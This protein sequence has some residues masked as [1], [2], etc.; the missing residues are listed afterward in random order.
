MR[1]FSILLSF[2]VCLPVLA[3]PLEFIVKE[4]G[5]GVPIEEATVV[6]EDGEI[7]GMTDK[8]G[9]LTLESSDLPVNIKILA[10]GYQSYKQTVSRSTLIKAYLYPVEEV[11]G[12][13]ITKDR[14]SENTSKFVLSAKELKSVAGTNGD[15]LVAVTSMPGVVAAGRDIYVRGSGG[16]DQ[17]AWVNK[18]PVDYLFHF[19]GVSTINPDLLEDFNLFSGG[20][21]VE[22]PNAIGGFLDV[23]LRKP[24]S[25]RFHQKYRIGI[26]EAAFLLEGP[27]WNKKNS[28]YFAARRSYIDLLVSPEELTDFMNDDDDAAI[29]NEINTVPRYND[30]Q[31]MWHSDLE[32]GDFFVQ[33][34]SASDALAL[35]NNKAVETDPEA[36]GLLSARLSYYTIGSGW[37]QKLADRWLSDVTFSYR[38]SKENFRIGTDPITGTSYFVDNEVRQFRSQPYLQWNLSEQ[39][40]VDFGAE[41]VYGE[42]PVNAFIS[43]EPT[44]NDPGFDF[45][46]ESKYRVNRT[47]YARS[48]SP[49]VKYV[50]QWNQRLRSQFGIRYSNISGTGGIDMHGLAPRLSLEYK[51]NNA[52][53]LNGVWGRYMQMPSTNSQLVEGLGNP[54]LS[55]TDAEHRIIGLR[56]EPKPH[57]LA[58]LEFFHTPVSDL[59]IKVDAAPPDNFVNAGEGESYGVDL[60]IKRDL[61]HRKT[62]WLSY[63]FIQSRRTNTLTSETRDYSGEIPHNLTLVWSQPMPGRWKQWLWGAKFV[64]RSG[65]PYT[66]VVG[67]TGIC[68]QAN[69]YVPCADQ[70]QP[71]NDANFS[72]WS[73]IRAQHNSDRLPFFYRV[74]FRVEKQ[75]RL[76]NSMFNFFFD[77]YNIS[78]SKNVIGYDYGNK[79]QNINKPKEITN[80]PFIPFIGVEITY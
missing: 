14:I 43:A 56:Y 66:R 20:F 64:A 26:T 18:L 54:R 69:A 32:N 8:S 42:F 22:Y 11:E 4:K 79:Y 76:N 38:V 27:L 31:A 60:F 71:E 2:F 7:H 13:S 49:Y 58:K 39:D 21:P 47:L 61:K 62:G 75:K 80:I 41:L 19:T 46:Q 40:Q 5:T 10:P 35:T 73:P 70:S 44:E 23:K 59:S 15:P 28:Y 17:G 34:L 55:M 78:L 33:F 68:R 1:T 57:W 3:Q 24:K 48:F 12:L 36:A 45:S 37:Q 74:D 65:A 9:R 6:I 77:F 67:R 25:D 53:S 72:F 29:K 16:G 52:L 63:S 50:R 51:I 30:V